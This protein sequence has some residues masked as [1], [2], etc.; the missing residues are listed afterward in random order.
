MCAFAFCPNWSG[1]SF[2][3]LALVVSGTWTWIPRYMKIPPFSK[4]IPCVG[5]Y[6]CLTIQAGCSQFCCNNLT[7][8]T[9]QFISKEIF[10]G[11]NGPVHNKNMKKKKPTPFWKRSLAILL[12]A[13]TKCIGLTF[14]VF[15]YKSSKFAS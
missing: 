13:L 5:N 7:S 10:V 6:S 15:N 14:S 3:P 11:Q 4:I 1:I 12:T 9:S 2:Q 8:R